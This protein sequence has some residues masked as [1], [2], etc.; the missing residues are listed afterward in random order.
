[1][2][3]PKLPESSNDAFAVVVLGMLAL[4]LLI[5]AF[6]APYRG[7]ET[8]VD[9]DIVTPQPRIAPPLNDP[10]WPSEF[11]RG[12]SKTPGQFIIRDRKT[13]VRLYLE[14]DGNMCLYPGPVRTTQPTWCTMTQNMGVTHA[15]LQEDGDFVIYAGASPVWSTGTNVPAGSS[16]GERILP[17]GG[18]G[19]R[20]G[21][22][23]L[24]DRHEVIWQSS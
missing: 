23:I 16:R 20:S 6:S 14:T 17:I 21:I 12:S 2:Q 4:A 18:V 22:R 7:K 10:G 1:M 5:A 9:I 13:N 15:T 8:F 19:M 3:V 24:N 11:T